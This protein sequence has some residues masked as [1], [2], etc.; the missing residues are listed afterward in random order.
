MLIV[1]TTQKCG[2]CQ[3]RNKTESTTHTTSK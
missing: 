1:T 2:R 3:H